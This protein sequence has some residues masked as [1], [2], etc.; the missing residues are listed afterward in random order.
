MS[1]ITKRL[2]S[3][4]YW[5]GLFV[6]AVPYAYQHFTLLEDLLGDNYNVAFFALGFL[7][8]VIR[9]RTTKPLQEK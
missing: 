1:W 3:K 6:M 5:Y 4:T 8:L 2:K 7:A 9:E